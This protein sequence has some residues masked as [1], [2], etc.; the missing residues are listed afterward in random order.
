METLNTQFARLPKCKLHPLPRVG[1]KEVSALPHS[2]PPLPL[3]RVDAD[4]SLRKPFPS[5]L[6]GRNTPAASVPPSLRLH[7]L[8][9]PRNRSQIRC[10]HGC[11]TATKIDPCELF[12]ME[13]SSSS[14]DSD[15]EDLLDDDIEQTT[16]ILAA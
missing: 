7:R 3:P 10:L 15:L 14:N 2:P 12:L 1:T 4:P 16:I 5:N 9:I 11:L 8:R 13:D 6:T